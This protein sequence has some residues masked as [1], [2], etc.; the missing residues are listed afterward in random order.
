MSANNPLIVGMDVHRKQHVACMMD[1]E[2]EEIGERFAVEN[3]RPGAET[4]VGQI[5]VQMEA[6]PFDVVKIAAEA[7]GWYWWH[8]FQTLDRDPF[9]NQWPVELYPI[10]P[11][12]TS[13]YRK[14][15]VDLDHTDLNDAFVVADKLRVGRDLPPPFHCDDLYFPLRLLTRY[16]FHLMH[17]LVRAKSYYLTMLYLKCSEYTRDA[18]RPFSD[19]FGAASRAVLHEFASIE[20]IAAIPFDDLVAFID[21]KG[22]RGFADPADNARRLQ[23]V[24][25]DSFTLPEAI[26]APVNFILTASGRHINC[27]NTQIKRIDAAIADH[28][29]SIPNTLQTIPGI[30][31]VFAAGLVAEIADPARFDFDQAKIAKFAGFKWRQHQSADFRADN[32]RLTR[33]GNRYLRYYF[34]EAANCVRLHDATYK[35][36]FHKK[37][38]EV[39][40]HQ[41]KRAIVLTARKLVRLVTRLLTTNQSYQPGRR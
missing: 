13:Q 40:S 37:F 12:L 41:H 27:L 21:A 36:Y 3:N 30:G 8:F 6:G 31:P 18:K 19:V 14:T 7:T 25:H 32:T 28:L 10:N 1:R 38:H 9:L 34:C 26:L 5:A 33:T 4:F 15:F 29:A 20:D 23:Q 16:R 2:G 22:R 11:R 24:A 39:R 17:S 35:A